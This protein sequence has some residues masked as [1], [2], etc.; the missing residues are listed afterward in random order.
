MCLLANLIDNRIASLVSFFSVAQE[1]NPLSNGD[2]VSSS[3]LMNIN[4][5]SSRNNFKLVLDSPDIRCI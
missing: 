4:C 2:S 5:I 1:A 3:G